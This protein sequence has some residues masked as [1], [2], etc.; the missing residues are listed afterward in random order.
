MSD[1]RK[2]F[3]L[4]KNQE[5]NNVLRFFEYVDGDLIWKDSGVDNFKNAHSHKSFVGR[6]VGKRA[7]T[8]NKYG[9]IRIKA[10]NKMYL[11]HRLIFYKFHGYLPDII[12]HI[13]RNSGNNR[14]ENLRP[15]NISQNLAN[16]RIS[17][18]NKSGCKGVHFNKNAQKWKAVISKNNEVRFLGYFENKE[19]AIKAREEAFYKAYGE[20]A[21]LGNQKTKELLK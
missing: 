4:F 2:E 18:G 14:V 7:G 12:D 15:A 8:V 9:Y 5:M 19:D 1:L 11:A 16:S 6:F 13:D 21:Y 20:Y 17:I 3:D 10:L